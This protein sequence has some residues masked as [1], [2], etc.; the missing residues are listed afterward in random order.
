MKKFIYIEASILKF[1]SN[2]KLASLQQ[3]T[4][5]LDYRSGERQQVAQDGALLSRERLGNSSN[6]PISII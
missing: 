6:I 5:L 1:N 4:L 2:W 3:F